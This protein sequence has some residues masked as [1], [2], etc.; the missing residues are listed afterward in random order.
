M[1]NHS[2]NDASRSVVT[3]VFLCA[4]L[5][6]LSSSVFAAGTPADLS[7]ASGNN[8]TVPAGT[9]VPVPVCAIVKDSGNNPV[10]GVNVT[11]GNVT[12]GG[13]ITGSDQ[14]TDGNG[15]ATLGSW[16]LGATAGTNT[17]TATV[18][19]LTDI[20]FTATGTAATSLIIAAGNN[21]SA[22]AGTRVNGVVC[23]LARDAANKPVQGVTVTWGSITG[24]GSITGAV[25]VTDKTGIATL[26]SWTLGPAAGTNTLTATSPGLNSLLFTATATT[27]LPPDNIVILW[28]NALLTSFVELNTAP[29]I[30]ARA[31][32]VLHT[33]IFDAWAPYDAK[34][35]GTQPGSPARRPF[36]ERTD[37]HKR[38]AISY[39]A[40][41]TL[42]DLF[43]AQKSHYDALMQALGLDP[44]NVSVD[45]TTPEGVGNVAAAANIAFRHADGSNQLGDLNPGAYSDYTSY[46]PVNTATTLNDPSRWQPLLQPNG[47]PQVFL[48]PQ[49]GVVKTFAI[50]ASDDKA[51]KKLMPKPPAKNPSKAFEKQAQE[52]LDLSANFTDTTKSIA[53]YWIDKAGTV[54]PPGH[55]FQ[56]AQ[57]VSR[58]DRHTVD[59]DV[60]LFFALGNAM[61]DASVQVW[62]CKRHYDSVRPITAVRFLYKN[63]TVKAWGGPNLGTQ[64]IQGE[65]WQPYIATP[66]FAEYVSGHSTFSAAG[67]QILLSFTR[68]PTF[69][70]SVDIPPGY[71]AA[72]LNVPAQSLT[73]T[74][75]KFIDAANAAGMSRRYGG[76]HFKDGD[77]AGRALGKKV[78]ILVWKKAQGYISGKVK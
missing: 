7:I 32:G 31:L 35:I 26:G 55:W 24:G 42:L 76:I 4:A 73:F 54:T 15:I 6:F 48:T 62:D 61:L 44:A 3:K 8:Q 72:E 58:R 43:P 22:P 75:D 10:S 27:P 29:T 9:A 21:Q 60:K 41:R 52:L 47:Q 23:V 1:K 17:L 25:E 11:F 71:T 56:F 14:V 68:N 12:G 20:T 51:R 19:G 74:F 34:A 16:T 38:I 53:A 13:T 66:G 50:G 67:A 49:W 37:F 65:T 28:N 33:S 64:N 5:L 45:V 59:D 78:A 57:F 36:E 39:A 63:K 70:F 2:M 18:A 46:A 30:S 77:M 69:G 40:Y